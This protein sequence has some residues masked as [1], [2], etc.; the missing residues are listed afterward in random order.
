MYVLDASNGLQQVK[1]IGLQAWSSPGHDAAWLKKLNAHVTAGSAKATSI[2][3]VDDMLFTVDWNYG[4]LY[5]YDL[6]TPASPRFMATHYAPF[7]LRAEA[8]PATRIVYMLAA[9][10]RWSGVYTVPISGS[11]TD[12]RPPTT[13]RAGSVSS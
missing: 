8:N 13:A 11:A 12:T 3:I 7:I 2:S 1:V 4:R 5:Y 10:G 6:G 9:Y